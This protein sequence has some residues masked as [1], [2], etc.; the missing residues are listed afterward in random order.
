MS[1]LFSEKKNTMNDIA[2][3]LNVCYRLWYMR[4]SCGEF[5]NVLFSIFVLQGGQ[6][7]TED[8]NL[9]LRWEL[10]NPPP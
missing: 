10:S 3:F 6:T 1:D 5:K 8:G 7:E 9:M 2:T 4:S